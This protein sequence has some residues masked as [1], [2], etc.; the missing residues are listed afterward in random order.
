VKA[1]RYTALC[2][3]CSATKSLAREDIMTGRNPV[4][5]TPG[6]GSAMVV[7]SGTGEPPVSIEPHDNP[8][9]LLRLHD[10]G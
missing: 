1:F 9:A 8:E 10:G 6:C 2:R 5:P 4:C 7:Y 3:S